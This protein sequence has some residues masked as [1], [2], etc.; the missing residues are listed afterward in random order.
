MQK[1]QIYSKKLA[2]KVTVGEVSKKK[3]K[4][5]LIGWTNSGWSKSGG[6]YM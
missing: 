2:K 5:N 4:T 1:V 3:V 6:W